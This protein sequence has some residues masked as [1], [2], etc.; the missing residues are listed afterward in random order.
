MLILQ[1][2]VAVIQTVLLVMIWMKLP[3]KQG[4]DQGM[5]DNDSIKS[6]P[7]DYAPAENTFETTAPAA[8]PEL[9]GEFFDASAP[10][11]DDVHAE[12]PEQFAFKQA[13]QLEL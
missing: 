7:E 2:L 3:D 1:F 10:L 12:M 4:Q 8:D 11:P 9:G 13:K 5:Q 6:N